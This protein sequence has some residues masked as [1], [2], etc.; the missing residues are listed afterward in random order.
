MARRRFEKLAPQFYGP[1]QIIPKVGSVTYKLEL[2]AQAKIHQVFHVSLLK[3]IQRSFP[4]EVDLPPELTVDME[5]HT[6]PEALQSPWHQPQGGI[7][8]ME[9]PTRGSHMQGS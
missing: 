1:F 7:D 3:R 4:T 2:P 5:L 6:E 9:E 8:T